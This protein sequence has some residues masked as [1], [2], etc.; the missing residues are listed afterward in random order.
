MFLLL[1]FGFHI[2][3]YLTFT[4]YT[5]TW[6][7]DT[8]HVSMTSHHLICS[9]GA[10]CWWYFLNNWLWAQCKCIGKTGYNKSGC[11]K[12]MLYVRQ[13]APG[14]LDWVCNASNLNFLQLSIKTDSSNVFACVQK[15]CS[16]FSWSV[17]SN[18]HFCTILSCVNSIFPWLK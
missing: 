10:C 18:M 13:P 14:M 7:G 5:C 12:A 1:G 3:V 8:Y 15:T 9:S 4:R 2:T 17:L 16:K 6:G 11:N